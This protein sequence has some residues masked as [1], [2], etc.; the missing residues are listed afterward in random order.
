M[1]RIGVTALISNSEVIEVLQGS[2]FKDKSFE[3]R[4]VRGGMI[5]SLIPDENGRYSPYPYAGSFRMEMTEGKSKDG[6]VTVICGHDGKEIKP[7]WVKNKHSQRLVDAEIDVRFSV[8]ELACIVT[9]DKDGRFTV[10]IARIE[11]HPD[12]IEIQERKLFSAVMKR[13]G[14]KFLLSENMFANSDWH[15][16]RD[17]AKAAICKANYRDG[18]GPMFFAEDKPLVVFHEVPAKAIVSS[19]GEC[20]AVFSGGMTMVGSQVS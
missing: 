12:Y 4:P 15:K 17:A 18:G 10:S 2:K 8:R 16:F 6:V 11:N 3:L 13:I 5:M 14:G 20:K 7:Y 1:K 9:L 19:D